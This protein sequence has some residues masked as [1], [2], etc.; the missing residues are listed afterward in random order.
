[1]YVLLALVKDAVLTHS[2]LFLYLNQA[3]DESVKIATTYNVKPIAG[4]TIVLCNVGSSMD[5]P[6]TSAKGLGQPR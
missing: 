4:T 1:M 3:L 5:T 2:R 6:C